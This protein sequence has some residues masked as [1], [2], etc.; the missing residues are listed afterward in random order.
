MKTRIIPF[1]F[2][3]FGIACPLAAQFQ[4]SNIEIVS[5]SGTGVGNV[6]S[7][8]T[9]NFNSGS[10]VNFGGAVANQLLYATNSSGTLAPL[11]LGAGLSISG[12][13]LVSASSSSHAPTAVVGLTVVTGSASTF[14]TSDSAPPISQAIIPTWTGLHSFAITSAITVGS[15]YGIKIVP[16]LNQRNATNFSAVFVN[17]TITQAGTGNQYLF[18]GEVSGTDEIWLSA[19]GVVG[20]S[21]AVWNGAAIGPTFGGTGLTSFTIGSVLA[22][23]AN[24]VWSAVS[25]VATGSIF[26][27][28][29]S[30]SLPAWTTVGNV[31]DTT[32][33]S[34]AE[35]D[36]L[37]RGGG[38]GNWGYLVPGTS[39]LFLQ[40]Q[41]PGA[42]PIWTA[43]GGGPPTTAAHDVA[44]YSN[45][46]GTF[47][48]QGTATMIPSVGMSVQGVDGSGAG[49]LRVINSQTSGAFYSAS[50]LDPSMSGGNEE[51]LAI[52]FNVSATNNAGYIGFN[53][54]SSGSSSNFLSFGFAGNADLMEMTT[55]GALKIKGTLAKYNNVSTVAWGVPGIYGYTRVTAQSG[56]R[57]NFATYTVGGSDGSFEVS[58]NVNAT[59]FATGTF[60]VTVGYTDE[61]N[62]SQVLTLSFSNLSGTFLTAIT[63]VTGTGPY[64]GVPLLIRCKASTAINIS[65]VGTFTSVTYNAEGFITQVD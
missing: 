48:D 53:F 6:D 64:E 22:A 33:A 10:T 42:L 61:T 12:G 24:N 57:S 47:E 50:I 31:L 1:L 38:S 44:S 28:T 14:M 65:T 41:G 4:F 43:A 35:G 2:A 23:S 30:A 56:A 49:I 58:A 18:E 25:A 55:G 40:S 51:F 21:T 36:I 32:A 27:S 9:W 11:T 20:P 19:T 54:S 52:G 59:A 29:G 60:T 8:A 39:G 45:T 62:T 34:P 46:T 3:L 7:G 17:E 13:T 63:S 16:T 26:A 15:D 37:I 5:A